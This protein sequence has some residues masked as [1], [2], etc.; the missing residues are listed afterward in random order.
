MLKKYRG[1]LLKD[2]CSILKLD[3]EYELIRNI[4]TP[5]AIIFKLNKELINKNFL[6]VLYNLI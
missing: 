1:E 2:V 5:V 3:Q 6:L 4:G